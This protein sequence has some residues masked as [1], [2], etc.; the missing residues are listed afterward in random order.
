MP[1]SIGIYHQGALVVTVYIT[2]DR[3]DR[4]IR[5]IDDSGTSNRRMFGA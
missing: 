5:L 2:L 4:R 3:G 1:I